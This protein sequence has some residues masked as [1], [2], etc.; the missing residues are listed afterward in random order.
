MKITRPNSPDAITSTRTCQI[1]IHMNKYAAYALLLTTAAVTHSFGAEVHLSRQPAASHSVSSLRTPSADKGCASL[2]VMYTGDA[3]ETVFFQETLKLKKAM[4][5]YK[6]VVLLKHNQTESWLD[7]SE[8][9]EKLADVKDLPTPANLERYLKQLADEGYVIDLYIVGH[10]TSG[11]F[12][13]S[14]GTYGS[15]NA[16][17]KAEIE[18][19]PAQTGYR[20]LPIRMVWSSLC[21]GQTLNSAWIAA[22]AKV[23]AGSRYVNF[24]PNRF[25]KFAEAWTDGASY[26]DAI[27]K[28]DTASSRT[29]VQVY[30]ATIHARANRSEWGKCPLGTTVLGKND[31]AEEYFTSRWLRKK[32]WQAKLSG[33]ENMNYSSQKI[34]AGNRKVTNKS[35]LT[36][37]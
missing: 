10:G 15:T 3:P 30:I 12:Y 16:V 21:Y 37:N 29:A 32:D 2:V 28:A 26:G 27:D 36:W 1:N 11:R 19:L 7:L 33:K 34:F 6:K 8:K 22:G 24:Y 9:D 4:K 31:C 13:L 23:V 14:K 17:T 5:G 25:V 18:A 35:H 20:Q